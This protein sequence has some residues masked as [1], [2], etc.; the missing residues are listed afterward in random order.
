[1]PELWVQHGEWQLLGE[2]CFSWQLLLVLTEEWCLG[3]RNGG[4]FFFL[5]PLRENRNIE[6]RGFKMGMVLGLCIILGGRN[7]KAQ[8]N[9]DQ[10]RERCVAACKWRSLLPFVPLVGSS[11]KTS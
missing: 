8:K 10:V 9:V 7:R 3:V 5:I 4:F 2:C 1:M 6:L 11:L